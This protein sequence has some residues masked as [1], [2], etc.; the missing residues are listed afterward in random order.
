ML[1]F[2]RLFRKTDDAVNTFLSGAFGGLATIFFS[3]TEFSMYL[4]GKALESLFYYACDKVCGCVMN[5]YHSRLF[6]TF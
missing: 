6:S 3:S 4:V 2:L 5:S 1:C